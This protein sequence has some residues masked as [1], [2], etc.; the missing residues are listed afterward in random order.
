MH[1]LLTDNPG[2]KMLMLGNEAIA[3]GAIEAGVAFTAS[4]PGTPSSE[5]SLNFFQMSKE[6]DLYFEYSIN[7]KVSVEVSAAAANCGVRSMC[8]MKH[9]GMNVAADA[10]LTLAY[11][12]VTG[13]MVILTADDPFMFSSQNEQD[14][15]YYGKLAGLPV[16]EPSSVAE[17][18][19]MTKQAFELSE[20]LGEPVILRTTTRINHSTGVVE[21]GDIT[22]RKTKGD[23]IKDPMRCVTVPAVSRG[24]HVKLLANLAKAEEIACTS[25]MNRVDGEGTLGIIVNGVSYSYVKDGLKD[26]GATDKV[27]VLRLGFSNPLPKELVLGFIKGCEKV[28]VVEE[29]EPFME[30]AVKAVAQ[31]NGLTLPICG[32]GEHLFSR[33]YEFDP[34]MVRNIM[35]SCFELAPVPSQSVD[36]S[37]VPEIP[38]RP[39]NLCAGC[40]HRATFYAVKQAT[41]GMDVIFPSDIGCY[42]LGFM[43]PLSTGDFV[44]CMGASTSTSAGFSTVTDKKVISFVGDSTFFHSGIM[45]LM[46]AVFN[47]HNFTLVILDNRITGMTGHQPN[48]GVDMDEMGFEGYNSIDI[49]GLVKAAGVKHVSVVRPYNLKKSIAAIKEAVEFEGVSVVIAKEKCTLYAKSLKQL[50]GKKFQVNPDKCKNHRDCIDTIACPAFTTEGGRVRINEEMCA[51]CAICAQICPENAI[52]PVKK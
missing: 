34:K 42:T 37:N 17:A 48:P 32:K 4:Y 30:E 50:T 5:I 35:A 39:P 51:G 6:S 44:L 2:Q 24:L 25:P 23:F 9:V 49:E 27:K 28:L 18:K 43:P 11:I 8:V 52:L 26:L 36:T 12:G 3:R 10:L 19:E 13:G 14:N 1:K 7:E 21:L 22:E 47:N 33:L 46:N 15:R 20:A 16:L 45:G 41:Q 29:G 31:E 40:S 38:N